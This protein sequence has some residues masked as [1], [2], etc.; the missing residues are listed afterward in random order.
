[1]GSLLWRMIIGKLTEQLSRPSIAL[2]M[3]LDGTGVADDLV[4]VM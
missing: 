2:I 1:V 3:A 4:A